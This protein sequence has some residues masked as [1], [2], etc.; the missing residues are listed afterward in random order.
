MFC[1]HEALRIKEW[2]HFMRTN[3]M[4]LELAGW[5]WLLAAGFLIGWILLAPWKNPAAAYGVDQADRGALVYKGYCITCHGDRG[6][7]LAEWR[8]TWDD[9]HQNCAKPSC[10][11]AQHPDTGFALPNNYAPAI[12]GENTLSHFQTARDLYGF[13]SKRMPFQEPGVLPMDDY[14][15]LTAFLIRQHGVLPDGVRLDESTAGT[16]PVHPGDLDLKWGGLA[17]GAVALAGLGIGIGFYWH[18]KT[19]HISSP[20]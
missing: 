10:H 4:R 7:G 19:K 15:A 16:Q 20:Q 1:I 2:L 3:A 9:A 18:R 8:L 12:M 5:R 6:Q 13:I 11:G 14:W 17:A